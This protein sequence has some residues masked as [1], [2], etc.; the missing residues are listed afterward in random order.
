[1]S[2]PDAKQEAAIDAI[3]MRRLSTDRAYIHAENAED[4]QARED[5]ITAEVVARIEQ[6]EL[7]Q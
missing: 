2:Y 1:M 6:K 3:V 5:Q 4:Q 7:S